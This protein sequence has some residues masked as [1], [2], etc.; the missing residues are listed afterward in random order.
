MPAGDKERI[1]LSRPVDVL[2]V[3]PETSAETPMVFRGDF[4]IPRHGAEPGSQGSG[5]ILTMRDVPVTV[6]LPG[7]GSGSLWVPRFM[8]SSFA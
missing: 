7:S 6:G 5:G 1:C 8:P 3:L 4:F 2:E